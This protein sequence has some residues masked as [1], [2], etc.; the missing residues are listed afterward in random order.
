MKPLSLEQRA[1][2]RAALGTD[3]HMLVR[4]NGRF[5]TA[6]MGGATFRI[7]TVRSL[8]VAGLM[9]HPTGS[10]AATLTSAGLVAAEAAAREYGQ[11]SANAV[12]HHARMIEDS[13][14]HAGRRRALAEAASA[15][16]PRRL[17][18]ADN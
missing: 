13:R 3:R 7:A 14:F 16:A 6:F 17:P 10:T 4:T 5:A 12:S 8:V 15:P 2:L 9:A 18:Y 11:A 1:C